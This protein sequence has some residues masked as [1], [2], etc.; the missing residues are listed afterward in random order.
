MLRLR[1]GISQC[2]ERH[3][4]DAKC[5][6]RAGRTLTVGRARTIFTRGRELEIGRVKRARG[7]LNRR[8][9]R[10]SRIG[11]RAALF[12]YKKHAVV[13]VTQGADRERPQHKTPL[14]YFLKENKHT[15]T[16]THTH[17]I[18]KTMI[19]KTS[20]DGFVRTYR[21]QNSKHVSYNDLTPLTH[22]C[23]RS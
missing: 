8:D 6:H 12:L 17:N 7:S 9:R 1:I 3:A 20:V 4:F 15:Q 18:H 2:L 14:C 5:G 11:L 23:P 16:Y 10:R 19:I 22:Q 21:T 13:G